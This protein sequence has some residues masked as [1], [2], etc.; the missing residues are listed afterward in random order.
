MDIAVESAEVDVRGTFP[1][2]LDVTDIAL[3]QLTYIVD[4]KSSAPVEQLR[5]LAQQADAQCYVAQSVRFA[6]ATEMV[7]RINGEEIG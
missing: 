3:R 6:V 2:G 7:V 5:E 1:W 4:L